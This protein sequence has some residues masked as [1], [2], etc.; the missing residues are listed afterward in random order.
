CIAGPLVMAA[1]VAC[2]RP[3]ERRMPSDEWSEGIA[4]S[5]RSWLV[6]DGYRHGDDRLLA[7]HGAA[8]IEVQGVDAGV[9]GRQADGR[10]PRLGTAAL[11]HGI[12]QE[13]TAGITVVEED[14]HPIDT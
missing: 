3:P 13:G 11:H 12:G 1:I 5:V 6:A 2:D 4:V 10:L 8:S 7:G 14:L 9:V